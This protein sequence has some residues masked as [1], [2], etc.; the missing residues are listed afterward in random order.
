MRGYPHME[1]R[2]LVL[3]ANQV[4]FQFVKGDPSLC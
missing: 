2:R 4:N 1:K 3:S